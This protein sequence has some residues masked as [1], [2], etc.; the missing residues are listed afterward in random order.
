[1]SGSSVTSKFVGPRTKCSSQSGEGY[2]VQELNG[3]EEGED[4]MTDEG[5]EGVEGQG[6]AGTTD[7]NGERQRK[8]IYCLDRRSEVLNE[9]LAKEVEENVRRREDIGSAAGELA[10]PQELKEMPI[11]PDSDPRKGR[12]MKTESAVASSGSL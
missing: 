8:Q 11:P 10:V 9:V 3:L 4:A 6:E 1:M 5:G 12:A 2:A 7:L